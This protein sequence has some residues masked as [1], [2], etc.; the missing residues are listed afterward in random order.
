MTDLP[1]HVR[2]SGD[3]PPLV[4]LHGNGEDARSLAPVAGGLA[5]DHRVIA[6]D[7]RAHGT[8]PRG[9]GPL[10]IPRMADDVADVLGGLRV[11]GPVD[12]VGY[13]DGGNVAL[14]LA[15]RHPA[16]VRSLV[17]YGANTDPAGLSGRTRAQVTLTWLAQRA[18]GLV[19]AR[20]RE[21]AEVTDLM[22]RHPR[23]PLRALARVDVPVLVAAGEHDVVRRAH[24]EAI[25]A[26]LPEG[27][28]H[29]VAGAG[30]GLPLDDPAAFTALVRAFLADLP[31]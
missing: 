20:A 24:T 27:R 1:L 22:V 31:A 11:T 23:I 3:G 10:T 25:A 18:R 4:L 6:P 15:L 12:V 8:S 29:V 2:V 5:D 14:L 30:H 13:S 19:D 9:T 26:H 21:R 16:L 28:V 7:A 17:L